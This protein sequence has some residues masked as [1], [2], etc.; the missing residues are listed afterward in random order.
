[1]SQIRAEEFPIL[2]DRVPRR[3]RPASRLANKNSARRI[4][5]VVPDLFRT[6]S[7]IEND[8]FPMGPTVSSN[9]WSTMLTGF[10]YLGNGPSRGGG[11]R[12]RTVRTVANSRL[13]AGLMGSITTLSRRVVDTTMD[14]QPARVAPASRYRGQGRF[15]LAIGPVLGVR[16][17]CRVS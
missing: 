4:V 17:P 6:P 1:M 15:I 7:L 11:G 14:F 9:P 2:R 10:A 5:L 12:N 3:T 8:S 13:N 16:G